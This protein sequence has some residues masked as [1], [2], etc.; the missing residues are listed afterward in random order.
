MGTGELESSDSTEDGW[1]DCGTCK[2]TGKVADR[3][4]PDPQLTGAVEALE[5]IAAVLEGEREGEDAAPAAHGIAT[6]ALHRYGGQ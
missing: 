6:E 1:W 2:G 3:R 4:R 5:R